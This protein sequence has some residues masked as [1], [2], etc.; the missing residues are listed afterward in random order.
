MPRCARRLF[1]Y[2]LA[3]RLVKLPGL[4]GSLSGDDVPLVPLHCL[5]HVINLRSQRV[6]FS[7]QLSNTSFPAYLYHLPSAVPS[8]SIF[9]RLEKIFVP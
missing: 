8:G 6:D 5:L 7:F 4:K 9:I 3:H 1:A 2:S